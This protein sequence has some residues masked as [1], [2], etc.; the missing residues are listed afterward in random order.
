V[1]FETFRNKL[2]KKIKEERLARG[3]TQEDMD[4]GDDGVPHRTMQNIET[5][6][7][8]PNLKTLFRLS[9]RLNISVSELT[10]V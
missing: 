9:K 7:S 2:G 1:N 3:F 8:N 10:D 5:G 6:K 4:E